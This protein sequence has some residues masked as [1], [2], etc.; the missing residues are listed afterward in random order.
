MMPSLGRLPF[1]IET[2]RGP[3][4]SLI[5]GTCWQTA[6]TKLVWG[7][8]TSPNGSSGR[9]PLCAVDLTFFLPACLPAAARHLRSITWT[10]GSR[11]ICFSFPQPSCFSTVP[12]RSPRET[13][14]FCPSSFLLSSQ[15][16]EP[17]ARKTG[18]SPCTYSAFPHVT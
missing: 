16:I 12:L 5:L 7:T 6:A 17:R 9:F 1:C 14:S 15:C 10:Q 4:P 13:C 8:H 3:K 2:I 18:F 11:R